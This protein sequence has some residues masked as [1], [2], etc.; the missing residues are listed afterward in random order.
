VRV[1]LSLAALLHL[2]AI[3]F[4]VAVALIGRGHRSPPGRHGELPPYTILGPLYREVERVRPWIAAMAALEYPRDRMDVQILVEPDDL[5][6]ARAA[7]AEL[8]RLG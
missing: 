1:G 4:R 5:V 8:D 2:I 6:T 7:R 3:L